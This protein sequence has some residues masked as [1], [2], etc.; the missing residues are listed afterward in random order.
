MSGEG[1]AVGGQGKAVGGQGKERQWE[2]KARGG[3]ACWQRTAGPWLG[4]AHHPD[5]EADQHDVRD[6]PGVAPDG[7][8]KRQWKDSEKGSGRSS[9]KAVERQ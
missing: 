4:S 7:R 6:V 1:K 2:V 8:G 5:G 3:S 9:G